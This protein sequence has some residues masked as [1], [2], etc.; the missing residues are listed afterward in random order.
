[1]YDIPHLFHLTLISVCLST[2]YE[3]KN[4][5]P[6][7]MKTKDSQMIS[8]L[9]YSISVFKSQS[10]AIS[11]SCNFAKIRDVIKQYLDRD[12]KVTRTL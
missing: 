6:L 12:I 9:C 7:T 2:K 3:I 11:C 8:Y 4:Y 1:M 10:S 5:L